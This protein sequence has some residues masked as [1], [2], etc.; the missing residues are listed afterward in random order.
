LGRYANVC[1]FRQAKLDSFEEDLG[2]VG[3]QFNV[4]VSILNVGYVLMQVSFWSL[5]KLL[6]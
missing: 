2:L 6:S 1:V 4:A 5:R 3:N